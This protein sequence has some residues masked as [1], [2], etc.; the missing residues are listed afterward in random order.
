MKKWKDSKRCSE[1]DTGP[2]TIVVTNR[3]PDCFGK[4]VMYCSKLELNGIALNVG[5]LTSLEPVLCLSKLKKAGFC[6][7]TV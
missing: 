4:W 7:I 1:L 3:N 2:L 6:S 5:T